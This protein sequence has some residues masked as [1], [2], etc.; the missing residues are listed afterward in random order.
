MTRK[1]DFSAEEWS[2]LLEGPPV[3]GLRV[4]TAE[5]GGTIRESLQMGQAYAEARKEH[6]S[7]DLLDD[8]VSEQPP[9]KPGQFGSV[10]DIREQASERLR[11]AVDLLEQKAA[12]EEAEAYKNFVVTLAQRVASAHKEGGV[13][14][15]GG[16]EISDSEQAALD[17]I[18][19]TLG[20]TASS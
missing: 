19:S 15:I 5:R 10:E 18:A 8:I 4:V 14:G 13:L 17:E 6:G 12:P 20:V 9:I 16:K 7:S 11:E 3:A 2:L 1:A